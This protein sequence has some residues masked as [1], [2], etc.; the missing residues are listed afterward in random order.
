MAEDRQ[1]L[2]RAIAAARVVMC[3]GPGGVGKTST[4]AALALHAAA[5]GRRVIVLTID[6]ARRL[7]NALGLPEIGN[8]ERVISKLAFEAAGLPVPKGRL[9]A[10][11]LDIKRTWDETVLRHHPDPE[12]REQLLNNRFYQTLS[13]ALAGSQ[14]YMA[15]EKLHEL[16]AR[17]HDPLDL[18]ILDTPP[19]TNA[20]DFLEAPSKMI[21][22]LDND[23]TRWLLEPYTARGRV[24]ARLFDAGSSL[25][26]RTLGRF[27]GVEVLQEL[28]ELLSC[29][30]GMFEGFRQRARS[31]RTTLA[32]ERTIFLVISAPRP[33]PLAEARA[34]RDRL[35][36][37]HFRVGALILNRA[38]VD[39]FG[40]SPPV[41][42][43]RIR[44]V[45]SAK[46][47]E[48]SLADRLSSAADLAHRLAKAEASAAAALGREVHLPVVLVPELDRD[49]H[50]LKGL[51]DLRRGL[52]GSL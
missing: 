38:H 29:F 11:M 42:I 45:I 21:D 51:E 44:E 46:G 27:T 40:A 37:D 47:G 41:S 13:T 31:V 17:R 23:A 48:T 28:A 15:M 14:E 30:Q 35:A 52:F 39:P 26:I 1:A 34:F 12:R 32:D 9:T 36:A 43:D 7:A 5:T 49:V 22:A 24:T 10:M 4:S 3:V 33:G 16:S 8:E 6:P 25:V 20:L 19:S 2:D 18:I 50:D